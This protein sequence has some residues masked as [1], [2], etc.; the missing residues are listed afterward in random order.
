MTTCSRLS[1]LKNSYLYFQICKPALCLGMAILSFYLSSD[2]STQR[3]M[4]RGRKRNKGEGTQT[5]KQKIDVCGV[6]FFGNHLLCHIVKQLH[7]LS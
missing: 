3:E 4:V 1:N 6:S 5:E 2:Y 7:E